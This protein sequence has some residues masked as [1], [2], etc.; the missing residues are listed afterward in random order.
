VADLLGACD[1]FVLPSRHEGLGVAAL[2]AMALARPV[3]ATHVGGLGE[4]VLH[5]RTGLLVPPDDA[6][7]LRAALARLLREP[8]LRE[9]L[10]AAGPARIAKRYHAEA[11]VEAY[12]RLYFEVLEERARA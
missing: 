8:L 10:G 7:A 1:I 5:Q 12:E 6:A 4:A 9:R 3:V 2:E 11:M